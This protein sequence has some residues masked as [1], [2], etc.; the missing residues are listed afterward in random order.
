M[1]CNE[2]R[3]LGFANAYGAPFAVLRT[4]ILAPVWLAAQ[5]SMQIAL[6]L[7]TAAL[8][9]HLELIDAAPNARALQAGFQLIPWP[10][11]QVYNRDCQQ[12]KL[13]KSMGQ[14]G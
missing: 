10:P 12:P 14:Q 6:A 8:L 3:L 13:G 5:P 1:Q 11:S 9:A 7:A 4:L 2:V